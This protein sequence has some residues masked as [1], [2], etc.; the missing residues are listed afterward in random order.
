MVLVVDDHPDTCVLL[1]K[2][3]RLSGLETEFVTSGPDALR[4]LG[5]KVPRLVILDVMMPDMDGIDTLRAIRKV[6]A[7][8]D[9]SVMMYS[10]DAAHDRMTEAM[11]AGA[12]LYVGTGPI[13][14]DAFVESVRLLINDKP[15]AS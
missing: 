5:L 15:A 13:G 7:Y 6:S 10:A 9:V 2:L 8:D 3:L 14:W 4:F 12:Q 11:R 1:T